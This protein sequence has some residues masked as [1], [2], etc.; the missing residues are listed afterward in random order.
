MASV[1]SEGLGY[2]FDPLGL[3][4]TRNWENTAAKVVV[5]FASFLV[6]ILTLGL[7]HGAFAYNAHKNLSQFISIKNNEPDTDFNYLIPHSHQT[8]KNNPNLGPLLQNNE[9]VF[10]SIGNDISKLTSILDHGILSK[11]AACEKQLN[12]PTTYG[13]KGV[14]GYNGENHISLCRAPFHQDA[15]GYDVGA[16]GV[17]ARRGI[18]FIV[19]SDMVQSMKKGTTMDSGIPG[20]CY[21][22]GTISRE[23]I[24]GIMVQ[25]ELLDLPLSEINFLA[26]GGAG[27]IHLRAQGLYQYIFKQTGFQDELAWSFIQSPAKN[28]EDRQHY[29][30]VMTAFVTQAYASTNITTM[31]DFL[32]L[33]IPCT[34]DV[35]DNRGFKITL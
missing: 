12:I 1:I 30:Q 11:A 20:E 3:S 4:E 22:S 21:I 28:Y 35:Y 19:S 6:G 25:T 15:N 32:K 7:L 27:T 31:R 29:E 13:A 17:Y 33:T 34:M 5:T 26:G 8:Q 9:L 24:T 10:H 14:N 2:F 23:N 16:F 18:T